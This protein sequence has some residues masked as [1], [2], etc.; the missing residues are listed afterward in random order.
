MWSE[1]LAEPRRDDLYLA[2]L[3]ERLVGCLPDWVPEAPG[4]VLKL[5]LFA[6][7]AAFAGTRGCA[8]L[9]TALAPR[10]ARAGTALHSRVC[11]LGV[12]CTCFTLNVESEGVA[13][14]GELAALLRMPFG[15]FVSGWNGCA[16]PLAATGKL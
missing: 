6:L 2:C 4:A 16:A 1:A 12:S 13:P 7:S 15:P 8:N 11:S 14:V 10:L 3:S 5:T 9:K